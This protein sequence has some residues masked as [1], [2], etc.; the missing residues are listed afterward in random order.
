MSMTTAP[1]T[2]GGSTACNTLEP[3]KWMSRPAI[4]S[5]A[6]ATR[7]AP[8]TF[9]DVTALRADGDDAADERGGGAEV[10]RH[11][12]IDD[13]QEADRRDA[14]HHDRELGVE[15]HDQR[16][17]ERRAEHGHDVLCTEADR[18]RPGEP[19]VRADHIPRRG[20]LSAV[21]NAPTKR[22]HVPLLRQ[23]REARQTRADGR[24][25]PPVGPR[26]RECDVD[27]TGN[28]LSTFA[29]LLGRPRQVVGLGTRAVT[30]VGVP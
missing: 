6:P 23:R 5:T 13:Q 7:I 27:L 25:A 9:A 17:D 2:A 15:T 4:A 16:E 3:R 12:A 11:A 22:S 24:Q 28:T 8:V 1:V 19:F 29:H 14:A 30:V 26:M 21:D 20:C 10:A 18:S